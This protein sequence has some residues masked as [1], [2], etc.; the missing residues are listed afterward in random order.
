MRLVEMGA[1][2]GLTAFASVGIVAMS[3]H[4]EAEAGTLHQR[5][6][7]GLTRAR[8]LV[9]HVDL[10]TGVIRLALPGETLAL[11]VGD[12]TTVFVNG[13]ISSAA[14][15]SVGR[16]VCAAWANTGDELPVAEWLEP[17]SR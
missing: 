12:M 14:E 7:P 2:V 4:P 9:E 11:R 3:W 16:Q 13:R 1:V 17:C 8:G 10:E 15:L 6:A 5:A